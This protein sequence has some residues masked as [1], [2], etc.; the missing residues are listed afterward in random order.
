MLIPDLNWLPTHMFKGIT[1]PTI[2][3]EPDIN[4]SYGGYYTHG[5]GHIVV[6]E[7]EDTLISI[8]AHEF[9]HY[10]QDLNGISVATDFQIVGTYEESIA[11]YFR[12]I[13]TEFDAL[14]FEYKYAKDACNEWW[15]RKLVLDK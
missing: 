11:S 7:D 3:F 8:I 15:L 14:L 1:Y 10:L 4:Q 9:R 12:N 5:T 2:S 6:V 13:P